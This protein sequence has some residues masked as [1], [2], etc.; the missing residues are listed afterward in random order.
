MDGPYGESLDGMI[1][2][3]ARLMIDSRGDVVEALA[4]LD[5]DGPD[6]CESF[7]VQRI[8]P[9][10]TAESCVFAFNGGVIGERM[11]RDIGVSL[12]IGGGR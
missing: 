12:Q 4:V 11:S 8:A 5:R 7:L 1:H 9:K 10:H 6:A 3:F 2:A